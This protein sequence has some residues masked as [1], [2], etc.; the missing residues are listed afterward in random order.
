MP[1]NRAYPAELEKAWIQHAMQVTRTAQ[2]RLAVERLAAEAGSLSDAFTTGRDPAFAGYNAN[3][4]ALAAYGLFFFPRAYVRTRLT[5]LEAHRRSDAFRGSREVRIVDIGAGTGA[6]GLAA[7][8]TVSEWLPEARLRLQLVDVASEGIDLSRSIFS[9]GRPLWPRAEV[10]PLASDALAF[11]PERDTDLILCSFAINEWMEKHPDFPLAE[12][13]GKMVRCLRPGG[14]LVLLEPSLRTSVERMERLRDIIARDQTARIVAP[15]PHHQAC[16]MLA[17]Q[18]GWCHEVRT[19]NVP[20]S[21]HWINRDLRRDVNLLKFS[22]LV[23]ENGP[24]P[25]TPETWTRLVSPLRAE[26]GKFAF[27]GCGPD[28]KIRSCEWLTRHLT[29]EQERLSEALERGDQVL[30]NASKILGDGT[31]ERSDGPPA[32]AE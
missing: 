3:R 20:E 26:K 7:L 23:L 13:V 10:R 22:M 25:K 15:C 32:R 16:P 8:H 14:W 21:L 5:L 12:W 18:R 30:W 6:A 1:S 9:A 31:T 24:A 2:P 29:P 4:K 11:A 17:E 27:H 19:W 28:G